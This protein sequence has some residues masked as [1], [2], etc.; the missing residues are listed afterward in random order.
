MQASQAVLRAEWR[1][2]HAAYHLGRGHGE[3]S[4]VFRLALH[5]VVLAWVSSLS[6]SLSFFFRWLTLLFPIHAD[7]SRANPDM[8][9]LCRN[10]QQ[11]IHWS[12]YC[13]DLQDDSAGRGAVFRRN[14]GVPVWFQPRSI[15]VGELVIA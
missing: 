13:H 3:C 4:L 10:P 15:L 8:M 11:P 2:W 14:D 12:L 7:N 9:T 1:A 6:L 5:A